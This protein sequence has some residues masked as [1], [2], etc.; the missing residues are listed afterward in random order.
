MT[1]FQQHPL[2]WRL[3]SPSAEQL[4]RVGLYYM[5]VE[6]RVKCFSCGVELE[7]WE[8]EGTPEP[9]VR[10][11]LARPHCSFLQQD[12]PEQLAALR[13]ISTTT[14]SQNYANTSLR[15]HSFAQW[16]YS[17][18]VT[19]YQLA[20]VG[21]YYTGEGA[22]VICFSCGLEIREWKR[23]DVPLLV[24]C[25]TNP[26]CPFIKS[27]IKG[28]PASAQAPT[29]VLKTLT[30]DSTAKP[31]FADVQVRLKSFKKLS[32]AFPILRQEL[33][34]A[35]LFLLRLPDVMKCHS[36]HCV[37][38]GWVE[39]D[40]AVE[41][42]RRASPDCPFLTERF[43]SKIDSAQNFDPSDLPAPQFD[44]SD[45]EMMARQQSASS[46]SYL[47]PTPSLSHTLTTS[48]PPP[49]TTLHPDSLPFGGLSISD[50]HT[51]P[52]SHHPHSPTSTHHASLADSQFPSLTEASLASPQPLSLSASL[53]HHPPSSPSL[54]ASSGYHSTERSRLYP[55]TPFTGSHSTHRNPP[56]GFQSSYPFREDRA[57]PHPSHVSSQFSATWSTEPPQSITSASITPPTVPPSTVPPLST[58]EVGGKAVSLPPSYSQPPHPP[59][60]TKTL[61][62]SAQVGI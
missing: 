44:E 11:Y 35:G 9:L 22:K 20:S 36:C 39:G 30:S 43:P 32:P 26:D 25:R 8:E 19:S 58:A 27:I 16:P 38:Q 46:T 17:N 54:Q 14:R 53:P 18:V 34:E 56:P 40:V 51:L 15:L 48:L 10:H 49:V 24:H 42:H 59:H 52:S 57:T 6:D 41:K 2:H 55:A 61:P 45:L 29:P 33:A 23:G 21:F 47:T 60:T 37:V 62:A 12:F 3:R 31:N 13:D 50:P 4:A 7:E 5:G 1:T 28:P